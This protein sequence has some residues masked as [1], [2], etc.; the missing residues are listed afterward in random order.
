MTD[1]IVQLE[2][3]GLRWPGLFDVW[4]SMNGHD[5]PGIGYQELMDVN[6]RMME[7]EAFA[8]DAE[9]AAAIVASMLKSSDPVHRH[10]L[11][12]NGFIDKRLMEMQEQLEVYES[13]LTSSIASRADVDRAVQ[14][15]QEIHD[16]TKAFGDRAKSGHVSAAATS[17]EPA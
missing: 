3:L 9:A 11:K 17:D 12:E 15:L 8:R 5:V 16:A 13:T 6:V 10:W 1:P 4:S 14:G 7:D 2:A